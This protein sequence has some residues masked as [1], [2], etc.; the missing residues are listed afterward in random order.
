MI[1]KSIKQCPERAIAVSSHHNKDSSNIVA[2]N[3]HLSLVT[4]N[5]KISIACLLLKPLPLLPSKS[6][7]LHTEILLHR[8]PRSNRPSPASSSKKKRILS[9]SKMRFR[10]WTQ[11]SNCDKTRIKRRLSIKKKL[12]KI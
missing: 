3:W 5:N 11:S 12:F 6:L 10:I 7:G 4:K 1:C 2:R 8:G 9:L